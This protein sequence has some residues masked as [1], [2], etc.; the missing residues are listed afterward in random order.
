MFIVNPALALYDPEMLYIECTNCGRPI[1]WDE[2]EATDFVAW[3]G[4]P[5]WAIDSSCC[6]LTSSCPACAPNKGGYSSW[7][8]KAAEMPEPEEVAA[9]EKPF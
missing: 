2:G 3:S 5:A 8:A 9:E 1:I 4:Y 6:I 7:L